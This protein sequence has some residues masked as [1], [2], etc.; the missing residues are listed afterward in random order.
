M[1]EIEKYMASIYAATEKKHAPKIAA[2]Q[3]IERR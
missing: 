2:A 1:N 3:K